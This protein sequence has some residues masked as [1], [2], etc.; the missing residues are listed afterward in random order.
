LPEIKL[1]TI[2]GC[3]GTQRL[4]RAVGKSRAMEHILTGN[5]ISATDASNWGL[6][7]RVIS[8]EKLVEEAIT[9]G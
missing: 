2:P 9:L 1:G 8:K 5:F 3:G 7:S 6:V 4:I